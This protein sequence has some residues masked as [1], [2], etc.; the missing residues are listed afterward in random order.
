MMLEKGV[1]RPCSSLAFHLPVSHPTL[2]PSSFLSLELFHSV[3]DLTFLSPKG[4]KRVNQCIFFYRLLF[5][6]VCV[7]AFETYFI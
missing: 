7:A 5:W 1:R 3:S 2:A 4:E 6:E